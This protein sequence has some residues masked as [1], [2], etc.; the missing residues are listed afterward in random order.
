MLGLYILLN[1]MDAG[2]KYIEEYG[3]L[4]NSIY[5]E[6]EIHSV[7]EHTALGSVKLSP[8]LKQNV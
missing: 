1:I 3:Q 4:S 5:S 6:V 2:M 8:V 7:S